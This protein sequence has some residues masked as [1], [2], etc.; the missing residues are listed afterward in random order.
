MTLGYVPFEI[1]RG[2]PSC[3]IRNMI[4]DRGK[5][6]YT[7]IP[8]PFSVND[9]RAVRIVMLSEAK[10]LASTAKEARS[11]AKSLRMTVEERETFLPKTAL[12]CPA[13]ESGRVA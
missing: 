13:A 2:N 7:N 9:F 3:I 10:H 8:V 6:M 11:F 4:P 1:S 12:G 5:G